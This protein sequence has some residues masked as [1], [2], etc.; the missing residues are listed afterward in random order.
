ME[1]SA[2]LVVPTR[3][4][5]S[6]RNNVMTTSLHVA[7][8]LPLSTLYHNNWEQAV[9]AHPDIGLTT[10]LLQLVCRSVT[11]CA[12]LRVNT[13]SPAEDVAKF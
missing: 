4:I 2:N 7:S 12:F 11:T 9:R 3:L 1:N 5:S 6:A 10:T 8:L 13:A